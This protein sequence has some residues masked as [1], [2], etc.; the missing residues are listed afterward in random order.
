MNGVNFKV[1]DIT[2]Q[3]HAEVKAK[4]TGNET[5][6]EYQTLLSGI[7]KT[8]NPDVTTGTNAIGGET[9]T[10]AGE[11]TVEF[12]LPDRG[13]D[14]IYKVYYF[15][16]LAGGGTHQS[17]KLILALPIIDEND[18]ELT[19]IHLYPKN[20]VDADDPEKEVVDDS[21]TKIEDN[22]DSVYDYDIGAK[23][24]YRVAF[25]MP[26][27]IGQ[28]I[29]VDSGAD[30][31]T[32]YT[33]FSI[34]DE[35]SQGGLKF[36]G[37]TKVLVDGVETPL[38]TI[39]PDSIATKTYAGLTGAAGEKAGFT[40]TTNLNAGKANAS[41]AEFN[42]S[43][44]AAD[45]LQN[46]A[47]KRIEIFYDV[48]ITENASVDVEINNEFKITVGQKGGD[49]TDQGVPD[50][51]KP[52]P[53]ITGGKKFMKVEAGKTGQG[54][55]GAE[56]VIIKKINGADHYLTVNAEGRYEWVAVDAEKKY[57]NA[58][59]VVSDTD[60]TF[61]ITG[62]DYGT[63]GLRE[64]KAPDGFKLLTTDQQFIVEKGSYEGSTAAIDHVENVS[65]GGFLPSTGGKGIVFFL[66]V[67]FALMATALYRYRRVQAQA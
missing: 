29:D 53:V 6:D 44:A 60:G 20:K 25:T 40:I 1:W 38:D 33:H 58:V 9:K 50:G 66:I 15:E 14:G 22:G 7:M 49:T 61:K 51:N 24:H 31:Q 67:G 21:G 62:L 45:H 59:K 4:E 34:H 41:A 55:A 18:V 8:F 30:K 11:G 36:E 39:L 17:Q 42:R 35:V 43:K 57:P 13:D 23:I 63:Y 54:L 10:T 65:K 47:G 2:E 27:Q 5:A 64:T 3:F 46:Y 16:E 32:R 26:S 19:D 56:F 28:I 12:T 37:I 48:S 52:D